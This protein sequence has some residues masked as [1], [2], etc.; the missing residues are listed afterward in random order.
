MTIDRLEEGLAVCEQEDGSFIHIPL[1]QIRGEA[2][3]GDILVEEASGL[4][5]V[6]EA[7]TRARREKMSRRQRR[8]FG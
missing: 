6:D 7:A 1:E 8:M 3:E 2:R 4:F 5:R